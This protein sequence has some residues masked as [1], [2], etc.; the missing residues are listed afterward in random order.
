M[1]LDEREKMA[2]QDHKGVDH[3]ELENYHNLAKDK[4]QGHTRC[5]PPWAPAPAAR[6]GGEA[7]QRQ[8]QRQ[9]H[10]GQRE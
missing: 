9:E 5:A 2:L 6:Q 4:V 7:R 10:L 3:K 1:F 8:R